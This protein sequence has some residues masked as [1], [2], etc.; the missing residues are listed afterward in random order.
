MV[1]KHETRLERSIVGENSEWH[2]KTGRAKCQS[3]QGK[4]FRRAELLRQELG[5]DFDSQPQVSPPQGFSVRGSR[6]NA[7]IPLSPQ[8][9]EKDSSLEH[10]CDLLN[11]GFQTTGHRKR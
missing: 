10:L 8:D 1:C 5:V 3:V 9:G 11:F 4:S 2:H 6:I 7:S